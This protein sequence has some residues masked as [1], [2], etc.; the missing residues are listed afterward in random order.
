VMKKQ[1][2]SRC[3]LL[4]SD[5]DSLVYFIES[6]DLNAELQTISEHFDFSNLKISAEDARKKCLDVEGWR[7][8]GDTYYHPLYDK[9]NKDKLGNLKDDVKGRIIAEFVGLR[10][11]MYAFRFADGRTYDF[12][13]REDHDEEPEEKVVA[14]GIPKRV[15]NE[16]L[17]FDKY[18]TCQAQETAQRVSFHKLESK[19][20]NIY[21]S[22]TSKQSL[23]AYD[24]KRYIL[25]DGIAT[26]AHGH[27][28]NV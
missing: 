17:K 16:V 1:F 2:G 8:E 7:L 23:S 9:D 12:D 6:E 22:E 3:K 13:D 11:K 5:T 24:D 21:L 20:H 27:Y 25:P 10:A 15:K 28:L 14:K 4:M 19:D 26:R 18:L